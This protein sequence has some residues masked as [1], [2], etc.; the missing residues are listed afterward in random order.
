MRS[1]SERYKISYFSFRSLVHL[2]FDELSGTNNLYK[3]NLHSAD[4]YC[5]QMTFTAATQ[6]H[7]GDQSDN[8]QYHIAAT[9]DGNRITTRPTRL[10]RKTSYIGN[11]KH[12]NMTNHDP[13]LSNGPP[14]HP[15]P[16]I[17]FKGRLGK[18]AT[19]NRTAHPD[20]ALKS[21][22]HNSGSFGRGYLVEAVVW[23]ADGED[24]AAWGRMLAAL[25]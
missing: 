18:R 1:E 3:R 5:S 16:P 2:G 21:P 23:Q 10:E 9:N 14:E 22:L 24:P 6:K 13:I 7:L 15:P 20:E 4:N 12:Q 11:C 25:S 19:V 17:D 8:N